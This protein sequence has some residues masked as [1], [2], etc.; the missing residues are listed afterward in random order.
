M[1]KDFW[2][3][4]LALLRKDNIPLYQALTKFHEESERIFY[5]DEIQNEDVV[6]TIE[7]DG[8]K[9]RMC[10][11]RNPKREG[12]L[13]AKGNVLPEYA[14]YVV[15][16]FGMGYHIEAMAKESQKEI[17]VLENDIEMLAI[18][19]RFRNL[20]TLLSNPKVKIV[21]CKEPKEYI[22]WLD[23][24][25]ETIKYCMWEPSVKATRNKEL[26]QI[27]ENYKVLFDSM[28]QQGQM[29]QDNFNQ[30]QRL[31]DPCVDVLQKEFQGKTMILLAG[32]PSLDDHMETLKKLKNRNDVIILCVGKVIKRVLQENVIPDYIVM[33]DGKPGT[34]WQI[35]GLEEC[36][37][38]LIYL[39]TVASNV[40]AQYKGKRYIAYQ[41]GVEAAK[42][43]GIEQGYTI[44]E[45]GGSVS[46]FAID[47]GIRMGC[48]RIITVGLDMGY[49][50]NETHAGHVGRKLVNEEKLRQVEGVGGT[51]VRTSKTLDIYRRWIERRIASVSG[52][53]MI[54]SSHGARIHGMIEKD[55][56]EIF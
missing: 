22:P 19:M 52:I 51:V 54:N 15:F 35:Q 23:G 37:I 45:S 36:G 26:R 31:K 13:F 17:L 14:G 7:D 16:G 48:L 10:S 21:F 30:N 49:P 20:N 47:M 43:Y 40:A 3:S 24:K 8:K 6:L 12:E 56:E 46:T 53:E 42:S 50:G 2:K 27:L 28:E 32:G 34:Y 29:L 4:N 33:I 44:Y 5:L 1:E 41:D 55:L 39:S 11:A 18:C 25:K 9:I 38:P